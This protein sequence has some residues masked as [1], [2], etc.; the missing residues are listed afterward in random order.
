VHFS[1]EAGVTPL[2]QRIHRRASAVEKRLSVAFELTIDDLRLMIV[3]PTAYRLRPSAFR[4]A[5]C[6][7]LVLFRGFLKVRGVSR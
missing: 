4:T 5:T 7:N 2:E 1:G 3:P 6:S